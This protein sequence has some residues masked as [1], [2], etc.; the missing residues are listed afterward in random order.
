MNRNEDDRVLLFYTQMTS[1][2]PF[3]M[4][5]TFGINAK[6]LLL[7]NTKKKSFPFFEIRQF[8][9]TGVCEMH[10]ILNTKR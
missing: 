4:N 10:H 1:G 5:E 9:D 3:L 7:Q 8:D 2:K 6:V